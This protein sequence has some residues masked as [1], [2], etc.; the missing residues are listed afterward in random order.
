VKI[1]K[2]A[3]ETYKDVMGD[4][5]E[6]FVIEIIDTFLESSPETIAELQSA[7]DQN[8]SATLRRAAHSLKSNGKTFGAAEFSKLAFELEEIGKSGD[9]ARVSDELDILNCEYQQIIS[10]LEAYKTSLR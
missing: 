8:D 10:E 5:Y 7:F 4:E 9:L 3:L 6:D 2:A 1:D